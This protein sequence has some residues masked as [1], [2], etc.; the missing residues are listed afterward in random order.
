MLTVFK[1][2]TQIFHVLRQCTPRLAGHKIE[3]LGRA[4]DCWK[5]MAEYIFRMQ[6]CL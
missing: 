1:H 4:L 6:I 5:A 2:V 3:Y